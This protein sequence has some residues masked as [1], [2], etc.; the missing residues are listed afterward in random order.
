MRSSDL[1]VI[2][3]MRRCIIVCQTNKRGTVGRPTQ[4]LEIASGA[5]IHAEHFASDLLGYSFQ[6][7]EYA[8]E[9]VIGYVC[10]DFGPGAA[11][12]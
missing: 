3:Q 9:A 7:T 5:G 8:E 4:V 6:P 12:V 2:D 1:P 10:S 11:P